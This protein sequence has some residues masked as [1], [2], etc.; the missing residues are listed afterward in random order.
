MCTI[1][2][3]EGGGGHVFPMANAPERKLG[4]IPDIIHQVVLGCFGLYFLLPKLRVYY[5][6]NY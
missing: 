2:N 6:V 3:S 4:M 5:Y 1:W